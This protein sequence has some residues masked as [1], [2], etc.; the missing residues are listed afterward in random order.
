MDQYKAGKAILGDF[1][2][3]SKLELKVDSIIC[4]PPFADSIKF[5]S[6]N[7]MRLWLCGWEPVD[8]KN[9]DSRFLDSRQ[10]KDFDIYYPFF[11]MCS[12]VL[13]TD[14]RVVLHLGKTKKTN[15]AKELSV[16]SSPWFEV[17]YSADESVNEIEKH[18]IKDKGGTVAHQ[19]LFLQK[20]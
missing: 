20:K 19:F 2:D 6:N 7:W 15:M 12:T 3:I 18:G 9:A 13:K 14:G 8:Y 10:K 11:E 5:Y 1:S 4:S 16:R 17:I